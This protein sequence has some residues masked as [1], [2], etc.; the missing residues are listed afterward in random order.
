MTKI[1]NYSLKIGYFPSFWR[2]SFVIPLHKS[3]NRRFID[4]Y[5]CIA[6][7]S[8]I[9]KLFELLVSRGMSHFIKSIL[10]PF[11]HGFMKGR[12]TTSNLL[13]FVCH[14]HNGFIN[15]QQTDAIYTDFSKAFDTV[16]HKLLLYKL[17]TMGFPT[18]LLVWTFII[19]GGSYP[20]SHF[21]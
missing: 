10:S 6:K 19:L 15:K 13:E 16:V 11:Q 21:Q 12:S 20:K 2:S 9:P 1:F 14:V 18:A 5:R 17:D 7:L 3:G 4:N 8:A